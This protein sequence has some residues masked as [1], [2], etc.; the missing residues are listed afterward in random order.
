[1]ARAAPAASSYW[2]GRGGSGGAGGNGGS[3]YSGSTFGGI[4]GGNGGNGGAGGSGGSG[5]YAGTGR[6]GATGGTGGFG[7]YAYGGGLYLNG[8]SVAVI[9]T[10]I[11]YNAALAGSGGLG[12]P[13]GNGGYV[14]WGGSGGWGGAGGNGGNGGGP[15]VNLTAGVGVPGNGGNG[16]TGGN[17]GS[18]GSGGYG[19]IGGYGGSGGNGGTAFGGGVSVSH[20][21]A[22]LKNDSVYSNLA[23][24]GNGGSGG[25]GGN[26]GTALFGGSAGLGGPGGNGGGPGWLQIH[27]RHHSL[28]VAGMGGNGGVGGNDGNGGYGGSGGRGGSGGNGGNGGAGVGGGLSV[29]S[30]SLTLNADTVSGNLA[31][32]GNGGWGGN[33]GNGGV[34]FDGGFGGYSLE[35][36]SSTTFGSFTF[37]FAPYNNGGNGGRL[38][39]SGAGG[40][41]I[42]GTAGLGGTGGNGGNGGHG[43]YGGTG[44]NGGNGGNGG[45]GVGGGI[46]VGPGSLTVYNSTIA[47]NNVAAGFGGGV[48]SGGFGGGVRTNGTGARSWL[49]AGRPDSAALAAA[50]SSR[51][52]PACPAPAAARAHPG[53]SG[54]AGS[55]SGSSGSAFGGGMYIGGGSVTLYNATVAYNNTGGGVFQFGGSLTAFNSLF[56]DNGYTGSS[57][58]A[59]A[60][61]YNSG[62][63]TS[64]GGTSYYGTGTFYNSLFGSA[65]VGALNGG[66]SFVS[67]NANLG[68][69]AWNGGPTQTIALLTGSDAIGNGMNPAADGTFLFTDQRGYVPTS[70]T[71]DIGAYQS[72]GVPAPAPTATLMAMNVSPQQYGQTTYDFTVEYFGA[73]GIQTELRVRGHRH[74]HAAGRRGLADRGDHRQY[75]GQPV[76][77]VR[78]LAGR[79]R[80]LSDHA[81]GRLVAVGGQRDVLDQP[82]RLADHRLGGQHRRAGHAGQLPRRDRRHHH[83]QVHPGPEQEDAPVDR[84][85]QADQQRRRGLRRADLRPV[86]PAAGSDPDE[87][88]RDL[89]RSAVFAGQRLEPGG[90]PERQRDG[91][92][93]HEPRPGQL[94]DHVLPRLAGIVIPASTQTITPAGASPRRPGPGQPTAGCPPRASI[95]PFL[96][97]RSIPPIPL[98]QPSIR[99]AIKAAGLRAGETRTPQWDHA[100]PDALAIVP[101]HTEPPPIAARRSKACV[102]GSGRPFPPACEL[103]EEMRLDGFRRNR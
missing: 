60:D 66:G 47:E 80:H 77:S 59:G 19:G 42:G 5:G 37:Y 73:A 85:D 99:Q 62:T 23:G 43:G 33:G 87:W 55:S 29:Y 61:Y 71:W 65:P 26:G 9:N 36:F 83:H 70:G 95:R 64:S 24:G 63:S 45:A 51:R 31:F 81:A 54:Y 22:Y 1:M 69:L 44:G 76:R 41:T 16:G 46:F 18:G 48:G 78:R 88:Q 35:Y 10:P 39:I 79:F 40:G 91:A 2:G 72:S 3:G 20:G 89:R 7:G 52:R 34:G 93:Q 103:N 75:V 92:V 102:R 67:P 82:G 101:P 15:W 96:P 4:N 12:G 57:G 6:T 32:G 56:A 100:G 28:I 94:L 21:S 97:R 11:A 30:G 13:G 74:G 25:N 84:D 58:A 14:Y 27:N 86:Q 53:S 8:G 90:G 17:G 98:P 50:A 38:S 49:A 68:P